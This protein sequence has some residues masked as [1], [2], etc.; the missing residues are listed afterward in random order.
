MTRRAA[1]IRSTI[2]S[3][4]LA[5]LLGF[6]ADALALPDPSEPGP[7]EVGYLRT[8]VTRAATLVDGDRAMDTFVWYPAIVD[9]EPLDGLGH[10]GATIRN[11]RH[12]LLVYSHGG[13][14]FPTVS[15]F[16]TKA[17]ASWGFVVIAP[18]HPGDTITDGTESCDWA[19][20]RTSTLI[21][22]V[23]DVRFVLDLLEQGD[24]SSLLTLSGHLD[25]ARTGVFGWS[26]GASTALVVGRE[27]AR[28]KAVLS[29]APD[30]RPERIGRSPPE[31][32]TMVMEGALDSYDPE[33]T[34]LAEIYGR[35][36]APR[37]AVE[38]QRTG[39]F[40]F[41]DDCYAALIDGLD[42][43]V[44]GTLGQEE[45]HRLVMRFAVPFLLR[46]VGRHPSWAALLRVGGDQD[47]EL[48]EDLGQGR[49]L[50]RRR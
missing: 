25:H 45:A 33:Q 20:L 39:H 32:P 14:A 4:L 27:D 15:S 12:P 10:A 47:A 13:C 7:Y 2:P 1:L 8:T 18:S 3:G 44:D 21:E 34:A 38:M 49:P 6:A 36:A 22:R 23:A 19:E 43:G 17:L 35:L 46:Y 48:S 24:D 28:I 29:L 40:A 31:A 5:W 30:V 50:L 16:L 37:F 11:G 9:G 26:S 41:S 42:C